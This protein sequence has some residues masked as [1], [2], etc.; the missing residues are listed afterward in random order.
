MWTQVYLEMKS[1]VSAIIIQFSYCYG[2][3]C[4]LSNSYVEVLTP[5][6]L[7]C[8]IWIQGLCGDN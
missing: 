8:D 1:L 7:E 3:N 6:T 4:V 5:R 2:L